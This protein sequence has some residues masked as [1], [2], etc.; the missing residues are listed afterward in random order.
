MIS[1][2]N[3]GKSNVARACVAFLVFKIKDF[4]LRF[5]LLQDA[6]MINDG[7]PASPNANN[8]PNGEE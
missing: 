1:L 7:S 8:Y 3:I 4:G 2:G 5:L 6:G